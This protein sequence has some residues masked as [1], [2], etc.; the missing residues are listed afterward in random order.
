MK[1]VLN[2]IVEN[3]LVGDGSELFEAIIT[4]DESKMQELITFL[5]YHRLDLFFWE[6]VKCRDI[7]ALFSEKQITSFKEK[8]QNYRFRHRNQIEVAKEISTLFHENELDFVFLKGLS[9]SLT[10][11]DNGWCRYFS[12]IDI[13]MP[14]KSAKEGARLLIEN[15]YQYGSLCKSSDPNAPC[16]IHRASQQEIYFS[17]VFTHELYNLVKVKEN[18]FISN[19]DINFEF[20]WQGLSNDRTKNLPFG[21]IKNRIKSFYFDNVELPIFEETVQFLHLCCH[22][23]NEAIYFALDS[24]YKGG[25]PKELLLFRVFDLIK[26]NELTLDKELLFG[27]AEQFGLLDKIKY[28]LC[29]LRELFHRD[30][31]LLLD[32]KEMTNE[33]LSVYYS[34]SKMKQT[35]PIDIMTRIYDLNEKEKVCQTLSWK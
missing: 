27:L 16:F 8:E 33:E 23:Y 26:F 21:L 15:G 1:E 34:K 12:D 10:K 17:E 28:S 20:S 11:Y 35:W 13:L 6:K 22:L 4:F 3:I 9:L 19:I 5:E 32:E 29:I 24:T 7:E 2:K 14:K 25:D 31:K 18:G 30:I